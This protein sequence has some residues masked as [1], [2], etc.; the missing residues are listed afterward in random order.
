MKHL[1]L[2]YFLMSAAAVADD[3]FACADPEIVAALL[4]S[5]PEGKSQYSTELPAAFSELR[6]PD[7]L[8]LM[9]SASNPMTVRAVFETSAD[10]DTAI[11]QTVELLVEDGWRDLASLMPIPR[12]GF[13]SNLIP[14]MAHL[15]RDTEPGLLSVSANDAG[16]QRFV[17]L[18]INNFGQLQTCQAMDARAAGVAAANGGNIYQDMP[19]LKL[20]DGVQSTNT[21]MGGSPGEFHSG[22]LAKTTMS[23]ASLISYVGDQIRNQGWVMD[24]NWSGNLSAGS[25]WSKKSSEDQTIIG[26]LHAYG[27][28]SDTHHVRFSI[29]RPGTGRAAAGLGQAIMMNSN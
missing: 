19:E 11:A 26:T 12:G 20:P 29:S 5:G 28:S 13:Q 16:G 2:V 27:V 3:P 15:C 23:R 4:G 24:T 22:V 18:S 17:S 10:P 9:G 7:S 14:R 8:H 1:I 6:V 21:G 25:I